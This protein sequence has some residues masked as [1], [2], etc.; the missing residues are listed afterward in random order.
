MFRLYSYHIM[1]FCCFLFQSAEITAQNIVPDPNFNEVQ[2]CPDRFNQVSKLQTWFALQ[3]SPD[4]YHCSFKGTD[5]INVSLKDSTGIIGI[6]GGPKHPS[7]TESAFS[8]KIWSSLSQPM[9]PG[10][11][12]LISVELAIANKDNPS[13]PCVDFGVRF[14][15]KESQK[16][17]EDVCCQNDMP[18]FRINTSSLIAGTYQTFTDI[19]VPDDSLQSIVL[20]LFCNEYTS[21][22]TCGDYL[23]QRLYISINSITVSPLRPACPKW[24]DFLTRVTPLYTE[25]TWKLSHYPPDATVSIEYKKYEDKEFKKLNF[26]NPIPASQQYFIDF[27]PVGK[28]KVYRLKYSDSHGNTFYST[29]REAHSL[30]SDAFRLSVNP[31]FRSYRLIYN[32]SRH[33]WVKLRCVSLSGHTVWKK[34]YHLS[35]GQAE[36]PFNLPDL[37]QGFYLFEVRS[38]QDVLLYR[39]QLLNP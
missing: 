1:I 9:D 37:T 20:G 30:R 38:V 3:G 11:A 29:L 19:F 6:W 15:R 4:F 8:E 16:W 13:S 36:I 18:H 2:D 32:S 24:D 31:N 27:D 25:L 7:C 17:R 14:S 22:S 23:N 34:K 28:S 35:K 5:L 33:R 12:Y 10:E 39:S 26:H 21:S